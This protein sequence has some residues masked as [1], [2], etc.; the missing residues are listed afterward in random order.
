[1]LCQILFFFFK[2]KT[3]YEMR[4]SDWSSDVCSSD[5]QGG[6]GLKQP[7]DSLVRGHRA[8]M[9]EDEIVPPAEPFAEP[10][11]LR[12]RRGGIDRGMNAVRNDMHALGRRAAQHQA[13]IR[14]RGWRE[15]QEIGR[16][17]V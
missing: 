6:E 13:L 9:H 15:E 12:W 4:I 5:L 17:H 7:V 2:Q 3:A 8:D 11:P 1:M 10:R 16:A 14:P